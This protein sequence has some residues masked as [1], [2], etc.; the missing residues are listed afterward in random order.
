MRTN[1]LVDK[2]RHSK[3]SIG[4]LLSA[5]VFWTLTVSCWSATTN[6]IPGP[7]EPVRSS[8]LITGS[9]FIQSTFNLND[10]QR[11]DAILREALAG[12]VP[13]RSR[14]L[15]AIQI[16]GK[17]L[18]GKHLTGTI[19]VTPD[20]FAIGTEADYIRMP[21]NPLT[22]QRIA[23]SMDMSLP[24]AKIVDIIYRN[25]KIRLEP[26]PMPPGDRMTSSQYYRDHNASITRQLS[27]KPTGVLIAGHKKDVVISNKLQN[28]AG[29][30]AIYGWHRWSSG[31]IQ[32]LSTVHHN[33]YADY[34]HGIRFVQNTMILNGKKVT[35]ASV[36][37]DPELAPLLS[38]EGAIRQSKIV[39][40]AMTNASAGT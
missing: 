23:N 26:K 22:A 2:E 9:K 33:K 40:P 39:L 32:P 13:K 12:N 31:P 34:S 7:S 8:K 35:Y 37:A 38:D 10:Q 25:A 30:V 21:M 11:E 14:Q 16:S 24:T 1:I 3:K 6:T 18:S 36:L 5:I 20:Y 4:R 15:V 27:G 28:T 19:Y 17:S 29:R